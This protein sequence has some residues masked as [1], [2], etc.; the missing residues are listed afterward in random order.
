MADKEP[1]QPRWS[2]ASKA[3]TAADRQPQRAPRKSP[4]LVLLSGPVIRATAL[5]H[6]LHR[7]GRLPLGCG[8]ARLKTSYIGSHTLAGFHQLFCDKANSIR[9]IGKRLISI[10]P[11]KYRLPFSW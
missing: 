11:R 9:N 3:V 2:A 10:V 8:N 1:R 5:W 4:R 6:I 7:R